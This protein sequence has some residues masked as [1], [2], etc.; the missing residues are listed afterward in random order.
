[1]SLT[2]TG[3][4]PERSGDDTLKS[5]FRRMGGDA[6]GETGGERGGERGGEKGGDVDA[7]RRGRVDDEGF[8]PPFA[9]RRSERERMRR[10]RRRGRG[11]DGGERSE[12]ADAEIAASAADGSRPLPVASMWRLLGA[13]K[14]TAEEVRDA[15]AGDG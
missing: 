15:R 10:R 3:F 4:K 1:M 7:V 14:I 12:R 2:A 11:R 5:A 8:F 9:L 13:R 6:D